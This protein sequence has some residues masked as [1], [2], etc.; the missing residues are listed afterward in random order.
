[1]S[2]NKWYRRKEAARATLP[3]RGGTFPFSI[4]G[5]IKCIRRSEKQ[6]THKCSAPLIPARK[7]VI[8]RDG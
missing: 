4:S 1:M 3:L 6:L 5:Q 2:S 8:A 7:S